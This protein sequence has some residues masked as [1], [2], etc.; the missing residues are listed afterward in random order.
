MMSDDQQLTLA[1]LGS[2]SVHLLDIELARPTKEEKELLLQVSE[3]ERCHQAWMFIIQAVKPLRNKLD[4]F[5]YDRY[6]ELIE[7]GLSCVTDLQSCLQFQF[8]YVYMH[9]LTFMVNCANFL[10]AV[11]TG[12]TLGVLF[13]RENETHGAPFVFPDLNRIQNEVTLLLV[14]SLFYQSFLSIGASLSYPLSAGDSKSS[15][16]RAYSIPLGQMCALL[17]QNLALINNVGDDTAETP[18]SSPATSPS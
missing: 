13:A 18:S 8:P 10:S 17:E 7:E 14:Q 1:R 5:S 11:G 12:L 6:V 9:M 3:N 15:G 4:H 2:L 16:K